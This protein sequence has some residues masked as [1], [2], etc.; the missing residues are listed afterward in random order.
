LTIRTIV[1]RFFSPRWPDIHE[2]DQN[3]VEK[4]AV[5]HAEKIATLPRWTPTINGMPV[6][7]N[8]NHGES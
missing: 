6:P 8:G 2:H 5:I 7:L 1:R 3:H 4:H